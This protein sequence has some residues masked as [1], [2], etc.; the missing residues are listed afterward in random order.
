MIIFHQNSN[1]DQ[2]IDFWPENVI[3]DHK[4]W[5]FAIISICDQKLYYKKCKNVLTKVPIFDQNFDFNQMPTF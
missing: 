3:F 4:F 2:I 5:F 1:F